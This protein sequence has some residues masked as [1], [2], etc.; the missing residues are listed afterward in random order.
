MA[1]T[2][3]TLD[4]LALVVVHN[5]PQALLVVLTTL[6][7]VLV[8][9]DIINGMMRSPFLNPN[10]WQPLTLVDVKQL[11]HNVRRFRFALP[12]QEQLL[13][14]PLGQHVSIKGSSKNG[15]GEVFRP[16]TPT[17]AIMQRGY[18]DFVIKLYPEGQMSQVL[19]AAEVG[20]SLL[21]KG[22]KGRFQYE[23]G[24][25][26]AIGMLAG[27]SGITP[28]YQVA[29]EILR[30]SNDDT[31]L[32]LVYANYTEDDI[33]LRKELDELAERH[34]NFSV[35]YVLNDPPRGWA[36]GKGF[37][38]AEMIKKHLPAPAADVVILRCGPAPMNKAMEAHLE[39]LGYPKEQQFQF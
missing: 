24:S 15:G 4:H 21:F 38:T 35:Y 12:H 29:T 11:S 20:D 27:G 7:I 10:T 13:G 9:K 2:T 8:G 1:D 34:A 36:G 33:L 28:M 25:K 26:R 22:P 3:A 17:T 32:S 39:A 31:H 16:Y 18:V 19:A 23:K 30:D 37:V 6:V 5:L 14:L